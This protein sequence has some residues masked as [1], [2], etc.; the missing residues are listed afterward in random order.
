MNNAIVVFL[1][2]EEEKSKEKARL[3]SGSERG[4]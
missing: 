1:Q 2:S 4:R 3:P